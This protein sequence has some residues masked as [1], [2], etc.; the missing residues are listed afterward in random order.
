[1]NPDKLTTPERALWDAFPRGE[2]VDLT[3]A[4]GVRARTIRAE[5]IAALLLGAVPGAPGHVPAIRVEGARITGPLNLGH[6]VIGGPVVLR[7][8]DFQD[9]LELTAVKA[10]GIDLGGSQLTGLLAPLAEI[11]GNLRLIECACRG[12]VVLTGARIAGA[13][14]L[15]RAHLDHPGEVALLGNRLVV[16]DDLLAQEAVIDGEFR[17]AGAQVGGMAGL[18]GATLRREGGRAL[19]AFNLTVGAGLLARSGFSATGEVA[20]TGARIDREVDFRGATLD[21][22]GGN[23]LMAVGLQAGA[24]LGLTEGFTARGSVHLSRA[25][26]GSEAL[27]SGG[28]FSNPGGDAIRCRYAQATTFVLDGGTE[29]EGTVDLRY[30]RFTDVRDD[31]ACWPAGIRLS[32]LSYDVLEPPLPAAER[33]RWLSR[34][35]DG[36]L[37]RNYETLAAMY[38]ALGD[39]AG[40]RAVQLAKERARRPQ[41]AWYGRAWSWLQEVTVGYGYRPLRATGWLAAFLAIGTLTFGLHHPPPLPDTAHP[42]FNP[43]I[44]TLDLLVPLVG[45][46]L[47]NSYDPQGPQRWLAYL[48]IATGWILVTTIAA[49]VLRVLRRQ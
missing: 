13:L 42:A 29:V 36:Y 30:S 19:N 38:R 34:D 31:P 11:D 7:H 26:I 28:R 40:A 23:A 33:I 44:Y 45:L 22:P 27:L 15:Q 49:G 9:R 32:G 20:L 37:P 43:F 25:K 46:G 16:N 21:N 39:D 8:C 17:L 18:D 3:R 35:T 48:L 24:F 12:Q 2:L 14:Q 5:V 10:R 47:R 1:V 4:R 6:A 41:L